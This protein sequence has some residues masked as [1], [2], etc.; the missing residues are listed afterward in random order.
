LSS[1]LLS[2]CSA[3]V[4]EGE[5]DSGLMPRD[6]RAPG[7]SAALDDAEAD[8]SAT[9]GC[10]AS[11][12][13]CNGRDDDCDGIVDEDFDLRTDASHCGGCGHVCTGD[14]ACS[15]GRCANEVDG[16]GAGH[17]HSCAVLHGGSVYCWG[18][19]DGRLGRDNGLDAAPKSA[20]APVAAL[21]DAVE[22]A[23]GRAFTC[24]R[25]RGGQ[26]TCWGRDDF[27][28]LGN[29][30]G[31]ESTSAP[32]A[33][34][35]ITDAVKI[36]TGSMHACALLAGG[37]VKCWGLGQDGRL[38]T[39]DVENR[40]APAAVAGL[41]DAVDLAAGERHTCAIRLGGAVV[42][43]GANGSG[44]VGDGTVIERQT[45]TLTGGVMGA[46]ELDA[47]S[48]HTCARMA[49]G[50]VRCWGRGTEGQLG[51]GT[52]PDAGPAM[53]T[54]ELPPAD[55][56]SAGHGNH[57][58]AISGDTAYCWGDNTTLQVDGSGASVMRR[59]VPTLVAADGPLLDLALGGTHSCAVANGNRV[60]CWGANDDG[61]CGN[62]VS[63]PL[64]APLDVMGLPAP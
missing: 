27:G 11:S 13:R 26:V 64:S 59:T 30:G 22:V 38:G 54:S 16:I 1:L 36:A 42:C 41:T 62:P 31:A 47:G 46:V 48:E 5:L 7:D 55:I 43:W 50:E 40:A 19:D 8:G 4:D 12:E 61:Q 44:Q 32:S 49:D 21:T 56:I 24:A 29:G 6:S 39:G 60:V 17:D 58:C 10:I 35:G 57:S 37:A 20:A 3:P 23:G 63:P 18:A 53:P 9:D 28:Q 51:M 33:V 15:D 14:T 34:M 52:T 45:P 2:G 25:R